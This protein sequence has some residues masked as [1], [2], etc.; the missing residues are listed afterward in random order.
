MNKKSA[1]FCG[2]IFYSEKWKITEK[3]YKYPLDK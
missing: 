3:N 2:S 1:R